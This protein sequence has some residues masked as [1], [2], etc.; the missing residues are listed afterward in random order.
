LPKRAVAKRSSGPDKPRDHATWVADHSGVQ[1]ERMAAADGTA[2][3]VGLQHVGYPFVEVVTSSDLEASLQAVG[4]EYV[5]RVAPFCGICSDIVVALRDDDRPFFGWIRRS[6]GDGETGDSRDPNGSYTVTRRSHGSTIDRTVLLLA[7]FRQ[8]DRSSLGGEVGLRLVMHVAPAGP[9]TF[10]IRVTGLTLSNLPA[11]LPGPTVDVLPSFQVLLNEL[12][13]RLLVYHNA[14]EVSVQGVAPDN[15]VGAK[16]LRVFCNSRARGERVFAYVNELSL[17]EKTLSTLATVELLSHATGPMAF[18]SD[19]ES[20]GFGPAE[21]TL[22]SRRPVRSHERL[23]PFLVSTTR[24]VSPLQRPDFEVRQ[25][26]IGHPDAPND[27]HKPQNINLTRQ[28]LRADALSAAHAFL[29]G[30]EL[31]QRF[32]AYGLSI[33]DYFKRAKLPIVLRHRAPIQGARD[34]NTVNA[35]VRPDNV[36]TSLV[37]SKSADP[38]PQ[39]EVSFGAANLRRRDQ[40]QMPRKRHRLQP[41]GIAADRRWAWHEFC[42][43]LNFASFGKL[44]FRFAHSAG[45]ALAAIVCDPDSALRMPPVP[46]GPFA[47]HITFP[48]VALGRRHDRDPARG[49]ACC[50]RRNLARLAASTAFDDQRRGYFEEQLLSSALFRFYRAIGGECAVT[51]DRR[52]A[53]DY[54]VYLIMRAIQAFDAMTTPTRTIDGFVNELMHADTATGHWDVTAPWPE[55]VAPRALHRVGGCVHKVIRWAF[56]RQGLYATNVPTETIEGVGK[57]PPVDIYIAD[58]RPGEG[59]SAPVQDGGYWPVPLQWSAADEPWHASDAGIRLR[60]GRLVVT[61][62]NR[63]TLPAPAVVVACWLWPVA[64]TAPPVYVPWAG[65]GSPPQDVPPGAAIEFEF[66]PGFALTGTTAYFVFAA[67]TCATDRANIDPA[68]GQPCAS[69]GAPLVDLV[70]NDNNLGLRV[71]TI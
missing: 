59:G 60:A 58:A 28:P 44:E 57:P 43:V 68:S 62:R 65:T 41:M 64:S 8:S 61:V 45:D 3:I 71:L 5:E 13:E 23:D 29:R 12:L 40:N 18:A 48:W 63:G 9:A 4:A 42:H 35:Q 27:P 67:A 19:P 1:V 51:D 26:R 56:E 50:G 34:G 24:L 69:L 39:I 54:A 36:V 33:D 37:P 70:A 7:G 17:P 2:T 31:V 20:C 46:G 25:T 14:D 21:T 6:W 66:G 30:G 52:A 49:W 38:R 16:A 47:R 11:A 53:S 10:A 32:T 55:G 22:A 15:P